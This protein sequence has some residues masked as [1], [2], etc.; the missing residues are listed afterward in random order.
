MSQILGVNYLVG[1]FGGLAGG[2]GVP[3]AYGVFRGWPV[4]LALLCGGT[5]QGVC[6]NT[7]LLRWAWST[8]SLNNVAT[9]PGSSRRL[10]TL[11]FR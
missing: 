3:T 4:M 5:M 10:P 6:G 9:S 11:G 1:R 2:P 8:G 7:A